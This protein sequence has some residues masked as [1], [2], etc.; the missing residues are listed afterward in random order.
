MSEV[1]FPTTTFVCLSWLG[2]LI[3]PDVVPG[4][5]TLLVTLLL[6]L[7]NILNHVSETVPSSDKF[8]AFG[9]WLVICI[10][11]VR[12]AAAAATS[13]TTAKKNPAIHFHFRQPHRL[14][15]LWPS[16]GSSCSCCA[17]PPL[18]RSSGAASRGGRVTMRR[19]PAPGSCAWRCP[20]S[21]GTP[22]SPSPSWPGSSGRYS[23][24]TTCACTRRRFRIRATQS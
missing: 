22:S 17:G 13:T 10:M 2:F 5:M 21:T 11:M 23:G 6:V 15:P 7:V 24:S 16:T 14:L 3:P 1:F 18:S 9:F 4:R 8:T 19:W 12:A 20:P